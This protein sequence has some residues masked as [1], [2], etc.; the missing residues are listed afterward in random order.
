MSRDPDEVLAD[1]SR[2]AEEQASR[3]AE[4]SRRVE[5]TKAS[6]ESHGGEV[7][8]VVDSS[9]GLADLRLTKQA[10]R[11]PPGRLASLILDTS[12]RAQAKMAQRVVDEVSSLYGPGS[13]TAS[14]I[15]DVY[16]SRFPNL[17]LKKEGGR[18]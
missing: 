8:V 16:T 10:M 3:A 7:V 11:L 15:G 2:R 9:G 18:R 6:F 1:W 12:R 5:Q 4:L 13:E 17:P 14:F